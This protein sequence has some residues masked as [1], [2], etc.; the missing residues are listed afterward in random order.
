MTQ[1][2][3][4]AIT[5]VTGN[6]N[7]LREVSQILK[8]NPDADA[9]LNI[10]SKKIDLPELQGEPHEIATEK[11][12]LAIKHVNGP[13]LVEDTSLCFNALHGLPGPYIKH[14]LDKLGHTGLNRMLS[15]FEDHSAYAVCTFA[16]CGGAGEEVFVFEGKTEGRIV[17]ARQKDEAAFGWD[18]IFEPKGFD[19]TYA[20][21][22]RE[23]KNRISHRRKGLEKVREH[24]EKV[25]VAN[26]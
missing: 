10:V 2:P 17:E 6:A 22:D 19:Q 25:L 1:Q 8:G 26:T 7:K 14:F 3:K 13:T 20:E 23:T 24:L 15:G 12:K 9:A 16:Y 11:C 18:P 21:M 5:F 4:T